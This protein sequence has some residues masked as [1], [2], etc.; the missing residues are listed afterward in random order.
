MGIFHIVYLFVFQ[1][2]YCIYDLKDFPNSLYLKGV[3]ERDVYSDS[4]HGS[5]NKIIS[6]NK[7]RVSTR[8]YIFNINSNFKRN[9]RHGRSNDENQLLLSV[10]LVY[11]KFLYSFMIKNKENTNNKKVVIPGKKTPKINDYGNKKR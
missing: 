3:E 6:L 1:I 10:K 2:V 4:G 5:S 9:N 11:Y 7:F 8:T